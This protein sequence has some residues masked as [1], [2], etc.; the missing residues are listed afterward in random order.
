[1][2]ETRNDLS[3]AYVRSLLDYDPAT[4]IFTWR[5]RNVIGNW[6]LRYAGRR[7]GSV[8]WDGY[9]TIG[10]DKTNYRSSRLAWLWMTGSWPEHQVDYKNRDVSDDS[11][12]NLRPA[13]H[14]Q[15][16]RNAK[17][18]K[19]SESGLKGVRREKKGRGWSARIQVDGKR[20]FLGYFSTK[21]EAWAARRQA[22]VRE[23]GEFAF[24]GAS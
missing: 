5:W 14:A 2:A 17:V 20:R 24:D 12:E 15:N 8:G 11:W 7:A 3:A 19:D 9:R 22:A 13:T 16:A 1:M 23:H 18:R 21:E 6:N 10:I 4:G